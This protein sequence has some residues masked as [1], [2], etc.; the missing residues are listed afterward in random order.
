MSI[1]DKFFKYN[2]D[3]QPITL[4]D[5]FPYKDQVVPG[6]FTRPMLTAES[7]DVLISLSNL[8]SQEEKAIGFHSPGS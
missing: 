6:D 7:I 1:F 2:R 5:E 3:L 4:G 8:S